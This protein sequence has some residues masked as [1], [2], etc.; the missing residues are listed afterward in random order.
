[1]G[2][3]FRQTVAGIFSNPAMTTA[4]LL[5]GHLASTLARAASSSGNYLLVA[6]ATTYYH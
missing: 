1:M 2:K 5:E 6:Q 3:S 4:L